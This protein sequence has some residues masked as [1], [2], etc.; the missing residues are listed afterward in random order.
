MNLMFMKEFP[1]GVSTKFREKICNCI[2]RVG[3]DI[4]Y[5][6]N[7]GDEFI[8]PKLHT[9]RPVSNGDDGKAKE[10]RIRKG[11]RLSFRYWSGKPYRSSQDEFAT[12]VCKLVQ[13]INIRYRHGVPFVFIDGIRKTR[14]QILELA[15]NDGFDSD[16]KFFKWFDKD[17]DGW[18]IHWTDKRY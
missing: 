3:G 10:C 5:L 12:G 8:R 17:F 18:L 6:L 1:W 14:D 11:M 16:E 7:P 2:I 13:Q 15:V 4:N 9:I